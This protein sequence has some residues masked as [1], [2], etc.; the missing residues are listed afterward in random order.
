VTANARG[1]RAASAINWFE[2]A[3]TLLLA[4]AT[5]A[6][7]WSGYQATRWSTET[8]KAFGRAN[9]ARV[10]SVK[11][12]GLGNTQKQV[13]IAVFMQWVDAYA[14]GETG[15]AGFYRARFRE[16]FKPAAEAWIASEPLQNPDAPLT[17]FVMPEY[18][19]AAEQEAERLEVKAQDEVA[20]A[21]EN[22][23]R[24]SNYV[25]G[26]VL[27]A[28]ALFF[29]GVSTKVTTAGL[30]VAILAMGCAVFLGTVAWIATFPVSVSL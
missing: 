11:A 14:G 19:L 20:S 25:L 13:D 12:A 23:Q 10:E 5:V 22:I 16:E 29:A 21:N 27:F 15:L 1:T 3:A 28:A 2:V 4:V 9:A 18:V 26:V 30:R 6:T 7:A 24:Q 8:A 17:P